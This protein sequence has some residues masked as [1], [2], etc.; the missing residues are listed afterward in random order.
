MVPRR[1]PPAAGFSLLEC[2]LVTLIL[3]VGLLGLAALQLATVRAQ[4]GTRTRLVADA[5]AV[6][7][8]ERALAGVDEGP[9][10][11]LFDRDGRPAGEPRACYAVTLAA[12]PGPAATLRLRATVTWAAGQPPGRRS[13]SLERLV[14]P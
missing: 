14:C 10:E 8:L 11:R 13:R 3:A 9:G 7:A 6:S 2:L 5:L 12:G 4:A 1:P